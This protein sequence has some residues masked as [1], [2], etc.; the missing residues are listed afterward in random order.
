[1]KRLLLGFIIM[2]TWMVVG[3]ETVIQTEGC[4][5]HWVKGGHQRGT[6]ELNRDSKKPYYQC[7][8][9]NPPHH[10]RERRPYG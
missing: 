3:C 8:D 1:M 10:D 9:E 2:A 6:R 4:F 5:G 7:V